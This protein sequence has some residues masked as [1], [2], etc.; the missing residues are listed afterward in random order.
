MSRSRLRLLIA[1]LIVGVSVFYLGW[2]DPGQKQKNADNK[3]AHPQ[4]D[5]FIKQS[6]SKDFGSDGFKT[7][8]LTSE[9]IEH[10]P[11]KQRLELLKPEIHFFE[12]GKLTNSVNSNQ[13][14]IPDQSKQIEF[15]GNVIIRDHQQPE[16]QQTINTE[17]LT[18]FTEKKLAKTAS[19]VTIS[20]QS[21]RTTGVGMQADFNVNTVELQSQVKGLH[22]VN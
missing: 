14:E 1:I 8:S 4:A 7:Q 16:K 11:A 18:V 3:P 22:Y 6:H 12:R 10:L 13:G 20:D 2:Q 9:F 5:Y 19:K 21:G 17:V 15:I